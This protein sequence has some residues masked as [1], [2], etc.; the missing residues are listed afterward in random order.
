[1]LIAATAQAGDQPE[2]QVKPLTI[3]STGAE[4][5]VTSDKYEIECM[6][7]DSCIPVLLIDV[8][9]FPDSV[10]GLEIEKIAADEPDA[11]A[12]TEKHFKDHDG[13]GK[14]ILLLD[15][16]EIEKGY[17]LK[18]KPIYKSTNSTAKDSTTID[19]M[20]VKAIKNDSTSFKDAPQAK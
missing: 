6:K 10:K 13:S 14:F 18:I 9:K 3:P 20:S 17:N 7:D 2:S 12:T 8:H 15:K 11:K 1:M 19:S 16:D 4:T 5:R